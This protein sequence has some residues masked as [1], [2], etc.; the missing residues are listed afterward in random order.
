MSSTSYSIYASE[1]PYRSATSFFFRYLTSIK[2]IQ[3][4]INKISKKKEDNKEAKPLFMSLEMHTMFAHF[5]CMAAIGNYEH[6]SVDF[7]F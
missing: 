7:N 2:K 4:F 6:I 3:S 5:W 1:R